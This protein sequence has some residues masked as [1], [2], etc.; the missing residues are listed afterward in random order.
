MSSSYSVDLS[1]VTSAIRSLENEIESL[2]RNIGTLSSTVRDMRDSISSLS[3]Q[4]SRLSEQVAIISKRQEAFDSRLTSLGKAVDSLEGSLSRKIDATS[5]R[6]ADKLEGIGESIEGV[7]KETQRGNKT[8]LDVQRRAE[9]TFK[10]LDALSNLVT[11]LE[12][13]LR[14]GLE[15]IRKAL[16]TLHEKS[17]D[18]S[19]S[20]EKSEETIQM[21]INRKSS[22]EMG[23]ITKGFGELMDR[24]KLLNASLD[25]SSKRSLEKLD[26]VRGELAGRLEKLLSETD[27]LYEEIRELVALLE[28]SRLELINLLDSLGSSVDTIKENVNLKLAE[29]A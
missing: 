27:T 11:G 14:S 8:L 28:D 3:S 24:L 23:V 21:Y 29:V 12:E 1:S 13:E 2:K 17:E 19:R 10:L 5:E 16:N 20:L 25:D 15:D 6:L 18:L 7:M 22:E 4:V 9:E 26:S